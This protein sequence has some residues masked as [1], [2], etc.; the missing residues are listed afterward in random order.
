MSSLRI[1]IG[2]VR[3]IV[4]ESLTPDLIVRYSQ[5]L[6][7]YL[8]G[9]KILMSRDTRCSGEMVANCALSGLIAAGCQVVDL[10]ICPTPALQLAVRSSD[11]VGGL[12]ITA[13]HNPAGW[14]A[15]KSVREDG[16]F[17]N[18]Q[19]ASELLEI[20]HQGEFLKSGWRTLRAVAHDAQAGD[21]HIEAICEQVDADVIRMAGLR[22]AVDCVNGACSAYAPRLL[23]LL[24]VDVVAMNTE[25]S[26][27]FPHPP[28]PSRE[29][30]SQLKAL[31]LAAGADVGFAFDADGDRLGIVCGGAGMV[32]GEEMTLCLAEEMVLRRG[33]EG[34]VVTNL[35]TTQAVDDIAAK[36]GRRVIRT[37]IG[38][39]YIG[40]AAS[41]YG[42]AIAGEGSGGVV[43]PKLHCA[44]DSM[45]AMAH[46]L[47]L[48]CTSG[49][50]AEELVSAVP[51]Y[52]MSKTTLQCPIET[53]FSILDDLRE[54]GAPAWATYTDLQDGIKY[55]NAEQWVHVRVSATEPLIRVITEARDLQTADMLSRQY[56]THVRH[57][58]GAG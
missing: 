5:A 21:R 6:A 19:Q 39:A 34:P 49:Q 45:A 11:A 3:G 24:G 28:E 18:A 16:I 50:S 43:F 2:G 58:M 13:G 37:H 51:E 20:Y 23:E 36:Y 26:L 55:G 52:H 32:P 54:S 8:E 30:M 14:N 4:G 35:S 46:I 1:T 10:G 17:F 15:L 7:T 29:N 41:N 9:G 12:A 25:T 57:M 27:A 38:Q 22:V 42:A 47:E 33:D 56:G 44:H 40:V 53:A 48:I 31:V